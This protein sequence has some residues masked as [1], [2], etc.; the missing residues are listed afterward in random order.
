[1][2]EEE[3]I[4]EIDIEKLKSITNLIF[5][6]IINGLNIKRV[7]LKKDYYWSMVD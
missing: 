4:M 1:M 6:H 7:E 2:R 5:D 3:P